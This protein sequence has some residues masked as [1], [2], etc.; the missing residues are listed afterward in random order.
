MALAGDE[1]QVGSVTASLPKVAQEQIAKLHPGMT[2]GE[3]GLHFEM[4]GGLFWPPTFRYYVRHIV[5]DGKLVMVELTFQPAGMPDDVFKDA[6]R[7]AEW[8]RTH[9]E[10]TSWDS[11]KDILRSVGSVSLSG[12]AID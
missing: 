2:R 12:G 9:A 11:P 5:V 10:Y 3:V 8:I 7:R 6:Q 1:P 4:D